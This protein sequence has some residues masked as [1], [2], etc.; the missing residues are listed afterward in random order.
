MRM[1]PLSVMLHYCLQCWS[2]EGTDPKRNFPIKLLSRDDGGGGVLRETMPHRGVSRTPSPHLPIH[3]VGPRD[4]HGSQPK[5]KLRRANV[6][7]L[8]LMML[9]RAIQALVS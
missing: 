8:R 6:F 3:S 4:P 2:K 5:L 7:K 9:T 1:H